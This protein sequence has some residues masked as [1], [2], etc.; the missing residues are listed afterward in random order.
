MSSL[1]SPGDPSLEPKYDGR[2]IAWT[3]IWTV[4]S[5]ITA[6]ADGS[7]RG[8]YLQQGMTVFFTFTLIGGSVTSWGTSGNWTFTFPPLTVFGSNGLTKAAIAQDVSGPVYY[9]GNCPD[10][11]GTTYIITSELSGGQAWGPS[12]PFAWAAGDVLVVSGWAALA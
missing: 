3:P 5:G 6:I 1:W 11:S 4:T 10:Q 9:N 7:F 12:Q 2:W 8:A